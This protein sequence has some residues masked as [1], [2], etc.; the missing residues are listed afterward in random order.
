M[1]EAARERGVGVI[2]EKGLERNIPCCMDGEAG[3]ICVAGIRQ[4]VKTQ[5]QPTVLLQVLHATCKHSRWTQHRDC[6]AILARNNRDHAVAA[7]AMQRTDFAK[8]K[9]AD[10]LHEWTESSALLLIVGREEVCLEGLPTVPGKA[11]FGRDPAT[12]EHGMGQQAAERQLRAELLLEVPEVAA[13]GQRLVHVLTE[14]ILCH[15]C[16]LYVSVGLHNT[17]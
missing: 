4:E 10:L 15:N 13:R 8:R 12:N 6:M 14:H 5:K 1:R 17:A 11:D 7:E 9:R 2:R 16:R 3:K